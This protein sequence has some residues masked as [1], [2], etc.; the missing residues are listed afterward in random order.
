[1]DSEFQRQQAAVEVDAVAP[2]ASGGPDIPA[3]EGKGRK[4]AATFIFLTI[5]L[6]MIAMG[7]IAPVLPK[8]IEGMVGGSAVLTATALGWFGTVWALMQFCCSPILGSL[9]DR[10]GR[11]PIVLLSNLG[12]GLDYFVMALAPTLGFLFIGRVISGI[13]ASSIPTAMA[14]AADVT[15]AAKRAGTFGMLSGAFGLGFVLG[16][17]IG[18]LLGNINPR[19]PF[20]VAGGL[21]LCN[22]CY[23]F[24]VLPES[25]SLANRMKFSWKRANPVGSLA[26]LRRHKEL[27][28]MAFVLLFGYLAQNSLMNVYVLYTDYRY[29]WT[30]RTIGLSLGV[31]G[32]FSAAIG[33]GLVKPAVKWIGER[34]TI[35]TGLLLGAT[36]YALIGYSRTGLLVW[37]SIP[38][39]NC[40]S[41]AWPTAQSL[42]TRHVSAGEQGQLQG[43]IQGLRGLAGLF[44]PGLFT[45]IFARS[46][47]NEHFRV[48]G[49]PFFTASALVGVSFVA[50]L[51]VTRNGLRSATPGHP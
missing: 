4:A 28:G 42:M 37:F 11:R 51:W 39:L 35:L 41:L 25:L 20:W 33:A 10:Y 34:R 46:I 47:S 22:F 14:Y 5:A 30:P 13:T 24:F 29:H 48:P 40:M 23:G 9:S 36:G 44:G 32:I 38:V 1:M 2:V 26:L 19:L 3:G 27:L 16:P 45:V 49:M 21:S 31:V 8:L 43:S 50:V 18:G 12:M 7:M 17:A 15:P 6:D